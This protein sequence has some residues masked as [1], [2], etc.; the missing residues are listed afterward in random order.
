MK[1][2]AGIKTPVF[3]LAAKIVQKSLMIVRFCLKFAISYIQDEES[4]YYRFRC[5]L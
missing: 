3:G 2:R 4:V 1:T 5:L